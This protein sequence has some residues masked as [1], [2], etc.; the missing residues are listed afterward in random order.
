MK[1]KVFI[2]PA[3]GRVSGQIE[4]RTVVEISE[5]KVVYDKLDRYGYEG[6]KKSVVFLTKEQAGNAKCLNAIRIEEITGQL[7]AGKR[8]AVL[9]RGEV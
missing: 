7:R 3:G 2:Y 8:F 1:L 6:A 5:H 4:E 9:D